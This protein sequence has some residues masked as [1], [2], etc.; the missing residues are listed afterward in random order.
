MG[1][2]VNTEEKII[3]MIAAGMNVARINFS[4][5][6]Y[7]E[8]KAT[9]DKLKSARK[10][11]GAP[12]AIL[13][14][15]KGPEIRVGVVKDDNIEVREK[16]RI[17]LVEKE[18]KDPN[19]IPIFPFSVLE[20]VSPGMRILFDDGF[21]ISE[22]I[23]KK[24]DF[25]VIEI[26]NNGRIKS[27]K[28]VN[29]PD[30][31][32]NLPPITEKDIEDI[33]F[34]CKEDIDMIAASFIRSGDHLLS[35]KQL[36]RQEGYSNIPVIA[37]IENKEGVE[38]FD[39]IVQVADGIMV[40]RGD[41]AVEVDLST[42]P[43]LQKMMI[44]KSYQRFKP[45]VTAT[46]MLDSMT[47]NPRPTRAEVSDVANAIYDSTSLVMLSGE[48]A[49]GKYPIE[50]I[51]QMKSII[52]QAEEHIDYKDFFKH[53]NG[54][55]DN[56]HDV[57]STVAIAAV[58]AS[59]SANAKAIFVVTS[60]GYTA[61]HLSRLRPKVPIV[62]FTKDEKN[63]HQLSFI[64]GVVP[65]YNKEC[66]SADQAL[67]L[68]MKFALEKKI[69]DFGDIIV[70]TAGVPFGKKGSTN[71]LRVEN[72]GSIL[73]RGC[74]GSGKKVKGEVVLIISAD[75]VKPEDVKGKIIVIPCCNKKYIPHMQQ[76]LGIILQN[77]SGDD[78]SEKHAIEISKIFDIPLIVRAD[79]AMSL[80]SDKQEV[81]LDPQKALVYKS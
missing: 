61:R 38:N 79:N 50:T 3:E 56:Y 42:V 31:Y 37:K 34:G 73:V 81:V 45:V 8:H 28:G 55:K 18:T 41:L 63:Y 72:V 60:S 24:K 71:M 36:L 6:S 68:L 11:A 52:K 9:I 29:I 17:K 77:I 53:Q 76:A 15:T 19:E 23:E 10:K 1:P 48:T 22:V 5:G 49:V 58:E 54:S 32:L 33:K 66:S 21:I 75:S 44:K 57:S 12:L 13:L 4:H 65:F 62:A 74:K 27:R 16:Q 40:A 25:V 67:E 2:S 80:L 64:W 59:Y 30:A 47:N 69:V 70:F 51:R 20:T 7:E 78:T 14:D 43:Y 46:Q 26:K 35:I 39:H